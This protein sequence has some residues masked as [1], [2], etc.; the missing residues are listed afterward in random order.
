M[1]NL[2]SDSIEPLKGC[3]LPLSSFSFTGLFGS[4]GCGKTTQLQ[5]IA[6]TIVQWSKSTT[7]DLDKPTI[8]N[9][10]VSHYIYISPST[11]TD[12]T[13][14]NKD[15]KILIQGTDDNILDLTESIKIMNDRFEQTIRVQNFLRQ[16]AKD[17]YKEIY[18]EV[19]LINRK[20]ILQ[21]HPQYNLILACL[22]SLNKF[23]Q[24][25]PELRFKE[26]DKNIIQVLSDMTSKQNNLFSRFEMCQHN[27]QSEIQFDGYMVRRP[28]IILIADDQAG[29]KLFTNTTSNPFYNL[30]CIRRHQALFFVGVSLHSPGN[31]QYSFKMQMNSMLL[32]RGIPQEKLKLLYDNIS[33]LDSID[34]NLNSFIKIYQDITGYNETDM[35]KKEQYRFNFVYVQSQPIQAIYRNFD[36]R[37][38]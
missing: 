18:N 34:F 6:D 30:L 28:K 10:L 24:D 26:T 36:T 5:N 29:S 37:L 25:Y 19:N 16:I 23:K 17:I 11:Q 35:T 12:H 38:K 8:C 33:S 9:G 2:T 22:A 13:L 20:Q 1:N 3:K 31:M 32:F 14:N 7:Y 27:S 15:S 21:S 4:P